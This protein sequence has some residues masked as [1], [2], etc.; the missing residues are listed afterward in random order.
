[1]VVLAAG[2]LGCSARELASE[3]DET[4]G[5]EPFEHCGQVE[6]CVEV[7]AII[8]VG[9]DFLCA[10]AQTGH[11]LT[12]PPFGD[13][14]VL[15]RLD[16]DELIEVAILESDDGCGSLVHDPIRD[17]LW[18]LDGPYQS[19]ARLRALDSDGVVEWERAVEPAQGWLYEHWLVPV[20]GELLLGGSV[21]DNFSDQ[22]FMLLERRDA[23]GEVIW[24]RTDY[25]GSFAAPISDVRDPLLD[26]AGL[27]LLAYRYGSD[28]SAIS[29]LRV[30]PS[31]GELLDAELL[32]GDDDHG[33]GFALGGD[34]DG[35]YLSVA[36]FGS[37]EG[38][39]A[40]V[41]LVA[42]PGPGA[43]EWT[44]ELAWPELGQLDAT[45]TAVVGDC[46]LTGVSTWSDES[47]WGV[48]RVIRHT[49]DGALACSA[50]LL[51]LEPGFARSMVRLSGGRVALMVDEGV[52]TGSN[53]TL[54]L[55][56]VPG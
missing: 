2:M 41:E 51:D 49:R 47:G 32:T 54:V 13:E 3:A 52:G 24:S 4:G 26:A 43:I 29:L 7:E 10:V 8:D 14:F 33:S 16:G 36:H 55:L 19:P 30:D 18:L 25:P 31:T 28:S 39:P 15:H 11:V 23:D 45:P 46:L 37:G 6:A 9:T 17:R 53:D 1:M 35:A 56:R 38:D 34:A 40:R 5:P 21:L 27:S 20:D 42:K 22:Q 48:D 44:S 12:K 50:S